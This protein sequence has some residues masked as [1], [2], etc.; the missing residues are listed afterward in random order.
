MV[1]KLD[2]EVGLRMAARRL[3]KSSSRESRLS[4]HGWFMERGDSTYSKRL[5][6]RAVMSV[7]FYH[8]IASITTVIIYYKI[9]VYQIKI[10]IIF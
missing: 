9:F 4:M 8:I 2:R 5:L 7:D 10:S 3:P 1:Q 6:L